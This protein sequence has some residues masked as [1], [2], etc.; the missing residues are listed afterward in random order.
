V[1]TLFLRQRYQESERQRSDQLQTLRVRRPVIVEAGRAAI[2]TVTPSLNAQTF[3]RRAAR[4]QFPA[5]DI[6]RGNPFNAIDLKLCRFLVRR[7]IERADEFVYAANRLAVDLFD[8]VSRDNRSVLRLSVG[9][10]TR[11]RQRTT[12]RH[13]KYLHTAADRE[14]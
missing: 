9:N 13:T 14:L 4:N 1:A 10:Q 6:E 3:L 12:G 5:R 11:L 7:L 8:R 2:A